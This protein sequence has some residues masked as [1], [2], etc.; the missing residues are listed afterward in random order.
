MQRYRLV[1]AAPPLFRSSKEEASGLS[2][3]PVL[4]CPGLSWLIL[5]V[6]VSTTLNGAN[7]RRDLRVGDVFLHDSAA[8]ELNAV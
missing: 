8:E 2:P 7:R 5:S 6:P 4:A 3:Q 1:L